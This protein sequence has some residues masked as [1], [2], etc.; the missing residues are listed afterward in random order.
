MENLFHMPVFDLYQGHMIRNN[1]WGVHLLFII[2]Q[3]KLIPAEGCYFTNMLILSKSRTGEILGVIGLKLSD[4]LVFS[5]QVVIRKLKFTRT[6]PII[7]LS[8][9]FRALKCICKYM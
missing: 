2:A 3:P 1:F 7:S 9:A 6:P 5:Q 4:I 8:V